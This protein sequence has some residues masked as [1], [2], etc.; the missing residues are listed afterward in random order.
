MVVY[1]ASRGEHIIAQ[2]GMILNRK[3]RNPF[4]YSVK[5]QAIMTAFYFLELFSG[6]KEKVKF[7]VFPKL[8]KLFHQG[9]KDVWD[10]FYP[11]KF[12]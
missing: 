12:L 2:K 6:K 7:D 9:K 8:T 5:T 11:I 1:Q 10:F 4:Q 3:S